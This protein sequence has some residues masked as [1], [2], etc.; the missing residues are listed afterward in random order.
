[1]IDNLVLWGYYG[2]NYGDDI[3]MEQIIDYFKN[4]INIY[5]ILTEET[6]F[7]LD[8][9]VNYIRKPV[10]NNRKEM[11]LWLDSLPKNSF[12]L[13]GGGTI[14]TDEEGDGNFYPFL[15]L[16]LKGNKFG[17]FSCGIGRLNKTTRKLK[18]WLLLNLCEFCLMREVASFKKACDFSTRD[19]IYL[20][21]DI[22]LNYAFGLNDSSLQFCPKDEYILFSWRNLANYSSIQSQLDNQKLFVD[23]LIETSKAT[24]INNFLALPIDQNVD[25]EPNEKIINSLKERGY[26]GKIVRPCNI[27]EITKYI[28]NSSFYYSGR[29]H[30]SMVSE[31]LGVP[32]F[33]FSYS[34]KIDCFYQKIKRKNYINITKEQMC[35]YKRVLSLMNKETVSLELSSSLVNAKKNFEIVELYLKNE[36]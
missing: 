25:I 21:D 7:K 5:V 17:Y 1:M 19:N 23:L 13:W 4:K 9:G 26:E 10:L 30:S 3:M 8:N 16:R 31:V 36:Q 27:S 11:N 2:V 15:Y 22:V 6:K 33:T 18:T 32:T 12:H 34:P 14:F 29:L 28:A 20:T 35:D 24:E